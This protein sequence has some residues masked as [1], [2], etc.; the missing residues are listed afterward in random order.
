[1]NFA[2]T[3][4]DW[5][6]CMRFSVRMLC[7]SHCFSNPRGKSGMQDNESNIGYTKTVTSMMPN[8]YY[9]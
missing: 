5:N 3:S 1:M 7:K 4:S 9:I 8:A 2:Y 6:I